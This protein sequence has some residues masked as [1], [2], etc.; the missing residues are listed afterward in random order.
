ML[1]KHKAVLHTLVQQ[2]TFMEAIGGAMEEE[3]AAQFTGLRAA[4]KSGNAVDA[5]RMEGIISGH[6]EVLEILRRFAAQYINE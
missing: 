6:E 5:A 4:V 2:P 1:D 3:A